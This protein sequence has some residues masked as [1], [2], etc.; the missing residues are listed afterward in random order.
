[1]F[2]AKARLERII[3]IIYFIGERKLRL[4]QRR[5]VRNYILVESLT[6]IN[7][8]L[9]CPVLRN[10]LFSIHTYIFIV[11]KQSLTHVDS[12][13]Q[14]LKNGIEEVFNNVKMVCFM[15]RRI[16]LQHNRIEGQILLVNPLNTTYT[17]SK[18]V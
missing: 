4:L 1:M 15:N 12:L 7:C 5:F 3:R 16:I 13:V 2:D 18:I 8:T 14:F 6:S 10:Y 9:F 17:C 11:F